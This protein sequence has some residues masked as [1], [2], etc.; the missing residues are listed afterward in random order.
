MGALARNLVCVDLRMVKQVLSKTS[1]VG[2]VVLE[3]SKLHMLRCV[4]PPL[5]III[6]FEEY[7]KFIHSNHLVKYNKEVY[8]L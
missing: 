4:H 7:K 6:I 8:A 5:D 3:L 2:F 1:F